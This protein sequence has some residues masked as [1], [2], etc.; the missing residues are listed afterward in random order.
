MTSLRDQPSVYNIPAGLSFAD[1]LAQGILERAAADP[2][3]LSRYTVLL[4]SR[5]A[6]RTLRDAFLR[7]SGGNAILLPR[8]QPLGDIDAEEVAL[9]S[10]GAGEGSEIPSA[11]SRLERQ[12]LLART[13]MKK[14]KE[15]SFDQAAS[16]ALELGR[17]LDE[18]Q[19]EGL[20]FKNLQDLVPE[21][22]SQHWQQT[23]EFLKILTE[24]WPDVLKERGVID[25]A[26]RR[27]LLLEAQVRIWME[28]PPEHPVIAAGS[29]GTVPASAELLCLV[30]K[31]PQ[32]MLI[33]PGLD[34]ALDDESW[35]KIGED[36]PQHNMKKLLARLDITRGDVREFKLR[37]MLE[38]NGHR[39]RLMTEAMRPPETTEQWRQLSSEDIPPQSLDGLKRID[40]D[41]PQEEADVIALLMREALT[42][43]GKTTA[44]I[45][46]DRR[47]ARRVS[48]SLRR[49]G[50]Q[51]DDSGGQ[52][53][54][55]LAPGTWLLLTA[56]MA[57]EALAPVT[58]LAFL[59][60]QMMAA[61]LPPAELQGMI[62]LLDRLVL[63]G[64]R[65]SGGFQG[66]RDAIAVL[67]ARHD[68]D[69]KN[70]LTWL[71]KVESVTGE[72]VALMS[73]KKEIPFRKLISTHIKMAEALAETQ[74]Q[75]G[76][77]RLWRNEAGE[78]ASEFLGSLLAAAP[79]VPDLSPE[80][81]ISLLRTLLKGVTVRPRHS[82]HPR[83][84][85]LGQVEARLYCAD[86]V[87]LGGLNE[88]TWPDLPAHDPWMSRPMRKKFGLPSPEKS[89]SLAAHDFVQ[90]VT[91][92][93]VVITRA[94]KVDGTPTVPARWLL[95]MEAVLKAVG[96][97]WQEIP[98]PYRDWL[99]EMDRPE[100]VQ[101][102][103]R[104]APT[105]PVAARPRN[106][107]VTKIESWMRDPY[108][109]YA[110]HILNLE[111]LDPL[112]ADP[113]G[114]ERG[115]FI[116]A[117]LEKFIRAYPKD[118]PE[119]AEEKLCSFGKEALAEMRVPEEVE[120]FWWPRFEKIARIFVIEERNWRERALPLLL[121][122]TGKW[123]FDAKAGP[124]TLKGKADRID[125]LRT[126]EYAIIDYKS[127]TT[128][129][130]TDVASGLSPQLPLEALL[131]EKNAFEGI[132]AAKVS[133]LAYWRVTGSGQ[134][135]V[136]FRSAIPKESG[137][138]EVLRQAEEGLRK[139]I[140][141]FD[142]EKTPYLS[143][144]RAGNKTGFSD[145]AHLARIKEWGLSGDD[146]E[147]A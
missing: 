59:K 103:I 23:L 32:G 6:C 121:E 19:T 75:A 136:E 125:R 21:D 92:R 71:E 81:Y 124:F 20:N 82:T 31:L 12:I 83:L 44:L 17:F 117:A 24:F 67:D 76:P 141:A 9:L 94:R 60:H 33:L 10:A 72:F 129:G 22:F 73:Q 138:E 119:A 101:A 34:V 36:H 104:P 3:V 98:H 128:P 18:V 5:R 28:N 39:V 108:Q 13:I 56:E 93:E 133:E 52:P 116:H 89:L 4:P 118:L 1:A 100:K 111:A 84:S 46:P 135:P 57:E 140:D 29:T 38:I 30:S 90:A 26:A 62:T 63:R 51:I 61:S 123:D 146:E 37:N 88:G 7:L 65:P 122:T 131:L 15:M 80:H 8:L 69:K 134:K 107:S 97:D 143:A 68:D 86:F 115:T 99:K 47:L 40:C 127:G 144:P 11:I 106:L 78:A 85:I 43:E 49:W 74:E 91:A 66:L 77:A 25:Y 55:E 145:Y 109:I 53:L 113:G 58:L 64:P 142:D 70:L 54:T 105:P 50:I 41:T 2:L 137:I 112:D 147:A 35:E 27:N 79:D 87:I 130:V 110:R 120:A 102:I 126:G 114:A 95:R 45:T 16:L 14:E 132:V 139:L 48:L 96:I 42:D